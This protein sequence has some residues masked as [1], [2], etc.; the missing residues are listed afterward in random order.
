MQSVVILELAVLRLFAYIV[1]EGRPRLT[2]PQ[3][4]LFLEGATNCIRI[5]YLAV[6]PYFSRGIYSDRTALWLLSNHLAIGSLSRAL[7]LVYYTQAAASSGIV[8]LRVS[9]PFWAATLISFCCAVLALDIISSALVFHASASIASNVLAM[10]KLVL[11]MVIVPPFELVLCILAY[12]HVLA[13]LRALPLTLLSKVKAAMGRTIFTSFC[14]VAFGS[15]LLF[16]LHSP[17]TLYV[18]VFAFRSSV[19]ATSLMH[20]RAR[21]AASCW[22]AAASARRATA[23]SPTLPP[24]CVRAARLSPR[25]CSSSARSRCACALALSAAL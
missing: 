1:E 13:R 24:R 7:F 10:F 21:G 11:A 17:V 22:S 18:V 14:S 16:S 19:N 5:A 4:L 15:L 23:R 2:I 12:R 25:R 6:D 8:T 20:V 9:R 3:V